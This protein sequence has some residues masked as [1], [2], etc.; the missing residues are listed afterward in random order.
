MGTNEGRRFD[1]LLEPEKRPRQGVYSSFFGTVSRRELC[2]VGFEPNPA[3]ARKLSRLM[4]GWR[5]LACV[6][7]VFPAAISNTNSRSLRIV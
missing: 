3:H 5:Q 2:V 7:H 4:P 6:F 1:I